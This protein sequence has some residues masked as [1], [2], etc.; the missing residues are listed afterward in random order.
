MTKSKSNIFYIDQQS[1][2]NLSVY[3]YSLLSRIDKGVEIHY[4]CNKLYDAD[5]LGYNVHYHKIFR[6]SRKQGLAKKVSYSIS[7]L[8]LLMFAL[9]YGPKA[10][11]QQWIKATFLDLMI[12]KICKLFFNSK[13]IYTAH[14]VL[15]H[16]GTVK[17]DNEYR[18][19][20]FSC[21]VIISHTVT[22]QKELV[23]TFPETES[24]IK[25]IPHGVLDFNIAQSEIDDA[26]Q[27]ILKQY[28]LKEKLILGM[29]GF[30]SLYKGSDIILKLW[31]N[32]SKLSANKDLRLLVV[33]K[34]EQEIIPDSLPSNVIVVDKYLANAEFEAFM[35]LT[36]V[37]LMPYRRIDQ[38]GLLLTI[39]NKQIPFCVSD[40][41]ELA[42]PLDIADVGWK[43]PSLEPN[44]VM[45]TIMK[46]VSSPDAIVAKKNN[47]DGWHKIQRYYDWSKSAILTER[48]YKLYC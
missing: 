32:S 41:G 36:N 4:F 3:D 48:L 21:D 10:I 26:K 16:I 9:W 33:G 35:E 7:I 19:V 6:Y 20:Y 25:I 22:S 23:A 44:D 43:F 28:D 37:I 11:H 12:W 38:S 15:P 27:Q 1:Y 47:A 30:Q 46:I 13:I 34:S 29:F 24:K 14:N 39:A 5:M 8:Q 31:S 42:K 17:S 40:V 45:S 2:G 18:K